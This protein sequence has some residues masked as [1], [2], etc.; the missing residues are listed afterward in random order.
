MLLTLFPEVFIPENNC[1][2]ISLFLYCQGPC[3]RD[4]RQHFVYI[5]AL[6]DI[7]KAPPV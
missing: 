6:S 7:T 4:F 2:I 1:G 3:S 5:G